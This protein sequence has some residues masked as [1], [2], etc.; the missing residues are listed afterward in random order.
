MVQRAKWFLFFFFSFL[1]LAANCGYSSIIQNVIQNEK[2]KTNG[3][4]ALT[5]DDGVSKNYDIILDILKKEKV[6]A[7]FFVIGETLVYPSNKQKLKRVYAN[8]HLIAN[9]TWNH[10]SLIN[11]NEEKLEKEILDT[12]KEIYRI[13]PLTTKYIRTPYG[14]INQKVLNNL[15]KLGYVSVYWNIDTKDWKRKSNQILEAYKKI[16]SN[17]DPKKTSFIS[18]HHD[19]RMETIKVLPEIIQLVKSKGFRFVRISECL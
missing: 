8:G 18:V 9:H 11:L 4:F 7:T 19:R 17:A 14:S 13:I 1:W 5:F 15:N 2:C 12:Q 3:M 10:F 6:K 16:L